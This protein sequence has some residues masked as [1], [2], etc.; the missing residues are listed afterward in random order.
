MLKEINRSD[1]GVSEYKGIGIYPNINI[2]FVPTNNN[3][4]EL[5]CYFI[6][7]RENQDYMALLRQRTNIKE[8]PVNIDNAFVDM[9]Q[10]YRELSRNIGRYEI[11]MKPIREDNRFMEMYKIID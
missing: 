11:G 10:V 8:G 5:Y 2:K 1:L 7:T 4:M 6:F 9:F 3:V